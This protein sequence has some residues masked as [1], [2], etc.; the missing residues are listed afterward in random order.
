MTSQ[1]VTFSE[2][3]ILLDNEGTM[4][5]TN[6]LVNHF[7]FNWVFHHWKYSFLFK[8]CKLYDICPNMLS[9]TIL[10][11]FLLHI[12]TILGWTLA[13]CGGANDYRIVEKTGEIL[14]YGC[15]L[16]LSF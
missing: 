15:S 3:Y 16:F 13:G 7:S 1:K 4:S 2:K 10:R 8:Y 6:V 5:S 11:L 9:E 12:E 14:T